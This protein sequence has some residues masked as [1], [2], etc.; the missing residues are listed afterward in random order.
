MQQETT[1][2]GLSLLVA[3]EL[4]PGDTELLPG[5]KVAVRTLELLQ[6]TVRLEMGLQVGLLGAPLGT[7][8]A[9]EGLLDRMLGAEV[10]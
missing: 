5:P 9:S 1:S 8:G 10:V 2:T 7:K 6:I 3:Q 4:V